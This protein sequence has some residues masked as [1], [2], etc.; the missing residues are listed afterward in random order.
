[1]NQ[2][3]FF[4]LFFPI[5][6]FILTTVLTSKLQSGTATTCC[7]RARLGPYFKLNHLFQASFI[8]CLAKSVFLSYPSYFAWQKASSYPMSRLAVKIKDKR[9]LKLIRKYLT[10]GTMI[11]GLV[12]PSIEG[13]PQG[14]LCKES[15]YAKETI[16]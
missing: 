15:N 16:K 12:T 8:L 1:M 10:A 3:Q 14:G 7:G 13:T 5:F 9:V 6:L 4:V 2:V 11:G